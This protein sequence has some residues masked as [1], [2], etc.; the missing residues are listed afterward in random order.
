MNCAIACNIGSQ[1]SSG[2]PPSRGPDH[3]NM[4]YKEFLPDNTSQVWIE[5]GFLPPIEYQRAVALLHRLAMNGEAGASLIASI[6]IAATAG[7]GRTTCSYRILDSARLR[8]TA[9]EYGID[10]AGRTDIELA[11]AVTRAIIAEYGDGTAEED[12]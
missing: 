9:R 4:F 11:R 12:A 8:R 3:Q 2:R 6:L 5:V 1:R 10:P 7:S